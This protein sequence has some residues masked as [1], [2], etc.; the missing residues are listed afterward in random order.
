MSARWL[1]TDAEDDKLQGLSCEAQ[2]IYM[3]L[4]RRYADFDTGVVSITLGQVKR[5]VEFIP[6]WGSKEQPRRVADVS[7]HYARARIAELERAG[8]VEKLPKVERFDAPKYR[9]LYA[10][11]ALIRP[12]KEPQRNRKERTASE[13]TVE[14][15]PQST[16]LRKG[17][18]REEPQYSRYQEI[19]TTTTARARVNVTDDSIPDE[20]PRRG[21]P[22]DWQPSEYAIAQLKDRFNSEEIAALLPEFRIYWNSRVNGNHLQ[23]LDHK[24]VQHAIR[25]ITAQRKRNE[26]SNSN[27]PKPRNTHEQNHA[28]FR[29][30]TKAP[31]PNIRQMHE[32]NQS[33]AERVI[34][35]AYAEMQRLAAEGGNG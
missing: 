5:T 25:T 34:A 8:L 22:A 27:Q 32:R 29:T 33:E 21:V 6:D 16:V 9:C 30:P 24:F 3:R 17:A 11:T 4:F 12:E 18:A 14:M 15:R 26:D 19:P 10:S 13:N 35:E 23:T 2:V 7:N 28:H 31:K 1:I 20:E